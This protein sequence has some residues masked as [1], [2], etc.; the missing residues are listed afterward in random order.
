MEILPII[1]SVASG[2]GAAAIVAGLF[3][4]AMNK[5]VSKDVCVAK[6][7]GDN[8]MMQSLTDRMS[9]LEGKVDMLLARR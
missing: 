8:G 5:K 7:E 9:R 2:I 3:W 1:T 6:H 4:R